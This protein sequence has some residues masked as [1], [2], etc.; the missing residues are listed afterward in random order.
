M[1]EHETYRVDVWDVDAF[2]AMLATFPESQQGRLTDLIAGHL[3][4]AP[5]QMFPPLLK[6]LHGPWRRTYRWEMG[7]NRMLYRVDD[8]SRVV[9]IFYLGAHPDWEKRAGLGGRR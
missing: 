6:Q 2:F 5:N 7:K 1:A 4:R 3:R 9:T 8:V